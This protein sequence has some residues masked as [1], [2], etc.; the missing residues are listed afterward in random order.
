VVLPGHVGKALRTVFPG[1]NLIT[2]R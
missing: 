1:Q 2:H